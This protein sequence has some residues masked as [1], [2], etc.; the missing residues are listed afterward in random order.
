VMG[1]VPGE[2]PSSWLPEALKAQAVAARSYALASDAGGEVFD[3]YPDTRSQVYRGMSG[4][5]AS[6]NAAVRETANQV[7]T[8]NGEIVTTFF[9]S[10]SGGHTEN[11]E[12]VWGGE[13][14]PYLRGV[15]DPYDRISP[16]HRWR[17]GPLTRAQVGRRF[18]G[19][20]RGSFRRLKVIRR[21]VSPRIVSA[22]VICSRGTVR[23]T[24][25]QLRST[26]GLYDNWFSVKRV[27]AGAVR[28][29][30]RAFGRI[31]PLTVR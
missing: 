3:Q 4:E 21:G 10:T 13:P 28:S 16:R 8:Y 11:I 6:T 24:G 19:L 9:F 29:V 18:G 31:G 30:A 14:L 17:I 12:N 20:C 27:D 5:V 7:V 15:D 26:L 23:T 25:S 22:D 1:V 2:M